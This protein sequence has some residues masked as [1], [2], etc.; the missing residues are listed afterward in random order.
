MNRRQKT[1][2]IRGMNFL[3]GVLGFGILSAGHLLEVR[4][5]S[6]IG[7]LLMAGGIIGGALFTVFGS[8]PLPTDSRQRVRHIFFMAFLTGLSGFGLGA[9]GHV[10]EIGWLPPIGSLM[11]VGGVI[12]GGVFWVFGL[13]E[14]VRG[15]AEGGAD[16]AVRVLREGLLGKEEGVRSGSQGPDSAPDGDGEVK[17]SDGGK[18]ERWG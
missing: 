4:W 1:Q 5:V 14:D 9:A 13:I 18:G 12:V 17:A 16:F 15:V 3:F 11:V 6:V 8:E 7:S 2:L 10:L